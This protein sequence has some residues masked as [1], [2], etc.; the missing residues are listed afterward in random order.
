MSLQARENGIKASR[1]GEVTRK[2]GTKA[3]RTNKVTRKNGIKARN[4]GLIKGIE[5]RYG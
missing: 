2:N 1:T 3:G 4:F 5:M